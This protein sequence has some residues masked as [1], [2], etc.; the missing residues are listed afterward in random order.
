MIGPFMGRERTVQSTDFVQYSSRKGVCDKQYQRLQ[1]DTDGFIFNMLNLET[2]Y[3]EVKL[4]EIEIHIFF[5]YHYLLEAHRIMREVENVLFYHCSL[6]LCSSV[7]RYSCLLVSQAQIKS[8]FPCALYLAT[9]KPFG[10]M[11]RLLL[12]Q[13]VYLD[14]SRLPREEIRCLS[15]LNHFSDTIV[16]K[17]LL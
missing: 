16:Q 13:D 9:I 1:S 11:R 10:Q 2:G 12:R 5:C 17:W 6:I 14:Y 4:R 3:T 7:R 15:R 8:V